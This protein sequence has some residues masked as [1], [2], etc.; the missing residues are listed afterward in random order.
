MTQS[1]RTFT[2]RLGYRPTEDDQAIEFEMVHRCMD[3]VVSVTRGFIAADYWLASVTDHLETRSW[4][5]EGDAST[6]RH[7]S[8][9]LTPLSDTQS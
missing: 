3:T 5:A 6:K 1:I 2:I 8:Q 4:T 7:E 9:P